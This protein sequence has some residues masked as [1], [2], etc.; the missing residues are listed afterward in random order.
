MK[1]IYI[2]EHFDFSAK[3]IEKLNTLGDVRY[4]EYRSNRNYQWY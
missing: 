4:F 2:L 1:K 3:Q